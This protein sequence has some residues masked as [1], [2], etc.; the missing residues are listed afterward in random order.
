MVRHHRLQLIPPLEEQLVAAR[1][2]AEGRAADDQAQRQLDDVVALDQVVPF[3][4]EHRAEARFVLGAAMRQRLGAG[5]LDV[6][7]R[8]NVAVDRRAHRCEHAVQQLQVLLLALCGVGAQRGGHRREELPLRVLLAAR[9]LEELAVHLDRR[10]EG[11]AEVLVLRLYCGV[12]DG[13]TVVR[14][15]HAEQGDRGSKRRAQPGR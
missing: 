11:G 1:V 13:R 14:L 2:G 12:K 9:P 10:G 8:L 6:E 4:K 5:S 3:V 15:C 7:G